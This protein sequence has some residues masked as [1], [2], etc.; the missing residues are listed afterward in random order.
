MI[1]FDDSNILGFYPEFVI[2]D[3]YGFKAPV[4]VEDAIAEIFIIEFLKQ[5]LK[6]SEK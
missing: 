4:N 5:S 1:E 2:I 3:G 6:K